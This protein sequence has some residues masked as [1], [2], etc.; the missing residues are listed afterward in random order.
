MGFYTVGPC[1]C[2]YWR[3]IGFPPPIYPN[4]S[5]VFDDDILIDN[6]AN[7]SM[8][9]TVMFFCNFKG[10]HNI[11]CQIQLVQNSLKIPF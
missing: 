10:E 7:I 11:V 3:T 6:N 1:L 2:Y 4:V 9:S 8:D 5:L